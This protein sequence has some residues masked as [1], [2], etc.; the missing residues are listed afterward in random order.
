MNREKPQRSA[1]NKLHSVTFYIPTAKIE[2]FTA[3]L[4]E[5][6]K[7]IY[8]NDKRNVSKYIR[9]LIYRDLQERGFLD[10]N[11]NSCKGIKDEDD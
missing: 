4:K 11:L 3:A 9:D 7:E 5:V 2:F 10:S 6:S 1:N 8:G